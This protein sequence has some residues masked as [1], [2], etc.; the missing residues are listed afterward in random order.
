[1]KKKKTQ[2][3]CPHCHQSANKVREVTMRHHLL[4]P[5]SINELDKEF[6]YCRNNLC[7]TGY[8]S[9]DEIYSINKFQAQEQIREGMI[10]F[11][12]GITESTFQRFQESDNTALFF[13]QLDHLAYNSECHCKI[14]NPAGLGCLKVFKSLCHNNVTS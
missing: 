8:F 4:F 7:E 9:V 10:C 1:M 5:F 11:C 13:E 14:K 12:F 3:S 6:F 2:A